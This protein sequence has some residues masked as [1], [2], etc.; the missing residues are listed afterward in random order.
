MLSFN[1]IF[2]SKSYIALKEICK[3]AFQSVF[4]FYELFIFRFFS[5]LSTTFKWKMCK[6][7]GTLVK[8][9]N[10]GN[11]SEQRPLLPSCS[12]NKF[13]GIGPG[14]GHQYLVVCDDVVWDQ[15]LQVTKYLGIELCWFSSLLWCFL[16]MSIYLLILEY[17]CLPVVGGGVLVSWNQPKH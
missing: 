15:K 2:D 6:F 12:S 4:W 8:N 17:W 16:L 5:T 14:L 9:S 10:Q 1:I 3:K 11:L 13:C 7:A